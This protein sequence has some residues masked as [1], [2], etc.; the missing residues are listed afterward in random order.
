MGL[1]RCP[2][3]HAVY[4]RKVEGEVLIV[5]VYVDDL[6]VT[7]TNVA[8]ISE[9]K[10]QMGETFDMSDLGTLSYYLESRLSREKGFSDSD[11][12]G[13]IDDRKSTGG[14]VFYLNESVI[15]WVSQKQKC[16]ALSSCEAEFMAATG[17]SVSRNMAAKVAWGK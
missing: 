8:V 3:E 15:T 9:F 17:S 6:L 11:L 13:H 7:G 14:V 16:V 12:A 4:T 5:A 10:E 1:T 2:Y